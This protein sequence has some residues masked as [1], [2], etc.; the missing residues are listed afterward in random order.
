MG[1]G[2]RTSKFI[3][4]HFMDET[5]I[6]FTFQNF[7]IEV[8]PMRI[9]KSRICNVVFEAQKCDLESAVML[10]CLDEMVEPDQV[11]D[12]A[13]QITSQLAVS[14][15]KLRGEQNRGPHAMKAIRS[16]IGR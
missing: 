6:G 2:R 10:G 3:E 4:I 5:Q 11:M 9:R 14:G 13:I 15:R 1:R 16:N 7:A 12:R 8:T